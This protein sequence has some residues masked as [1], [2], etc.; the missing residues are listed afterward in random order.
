MKKW[1][2]LFLM[3]LLSFSLSAK[4]TQSGQLHIAVNSA[5]NNKGYIEIHLLKNTK[6]F[7]DTEPPFKSCRVRVNQLKARCNLS[8]IPYG[9]YAIFTFHDEN[10]DKKLNLNFMGV[11]SEK[12]AIS[13]VDLGS[14]ENPT[15]KQSLFL[16]NQPDS[17]IFINLQ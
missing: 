4:E 3:S 15:F 11:P 16:V 12:L 5:S 2:I 10:S 6:Q 17:L 14:N 9:E 13:A 7:D 1:N 8:D